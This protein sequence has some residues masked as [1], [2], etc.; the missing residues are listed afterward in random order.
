[1]RKQVKIFVSYASR[2]KELVSGFLYKFREQVA[3]SKKY[4]YIFWK[5]TNILV[6]ENWNAEISDAL[7]KCD[8]GLLLISPAFLGSKY[9]LGN[10]LPHFVGSESKPVIP[11]MIQ[12]V[13]FKR[14]DLKGLLESQIFRLNKPSFGFPRAYG[15]CKP[16]RKDDFALELFKQ[17]DDRLSKVFGLVGGK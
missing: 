15:E 10:E 6:G 5:D 4:D 13:D 14:H 9:I 16:N 8:V 17:V 12:P 2:N 1:M 11:V 3:P 7:K